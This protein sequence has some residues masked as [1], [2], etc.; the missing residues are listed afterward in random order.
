VYTFEFSDDGHRRRS[1]S[2]VI[3]GARVES[4][5]LEPFLLQ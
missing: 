2:I 5:E 1:G 3:A 4:L